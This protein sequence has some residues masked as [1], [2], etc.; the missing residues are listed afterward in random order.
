[1]D[2]SQLQRGD[3]VRG[4]QVDATAHREQKRQRRLWKLVALLGVPLAWFWVRQ[5]SGNPVSPGLP[6]LVR[7]SPELSLLAVMMVL[8]LLIVSVFYIRRMIR[9]IDEAS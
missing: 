6:A 9:Q 4:H 7:E 2:V 1:M 8:M 3:V 5:L